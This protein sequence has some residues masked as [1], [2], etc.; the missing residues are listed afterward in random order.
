MFARPSC[1]VV[2]L[3]DGGSNGMTRPNDARFE[4]F[5]LILSVTSETRAE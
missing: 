5:G 1:D 3:V 4:T 2:C